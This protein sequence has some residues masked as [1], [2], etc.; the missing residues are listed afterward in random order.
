MLLYTIFIFGCI[1]LLIIFMASIP[2]MRICYPKGAEAMSK[3]LY[4]GVPMRMAFEFYFILALTSWHNM[5]G[6]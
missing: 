1:I 4:W 3:R 6:P 2:L 5:K